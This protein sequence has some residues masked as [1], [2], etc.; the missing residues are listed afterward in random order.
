[1]SWRTA[2]L[3]EFTPRVSRL[4]LV[5]DPDDLLAEEGVLTGIRER[6]FELIEFEDAVSFR[7]A[8]ESRFRS[9]WDDGEDTD[10][11]VVLRAQSEDLSSLPY[12]LLQAG[13]QLSFSLGDLFPSLGYRVVASLDRSYLD[14]L[15]EAQAAHRPARLGDNATKGFVLRHVFDI[16]PE[17][18]KAPSDLLRVLLRRHYAG[19]IVPSLLDERFVEHLRRQESFAGWPLE[20]IVPERD[21]FFS[22]LQERWG[23]FVDLSAAIPADGVGEA[24]AA[25][26]MRFPGPLDLPFEHQ[27]VRIYLDNLFLEG[28][29]RPVRRPDG[30]RLATSWIRVG[31]Q[32]DP[33]ADGLARLQGLLESLQEG[34]PTEESTHRDW[35][36]FAR[37][38]AELTA[39]AIS[40]SEGMPASLAESVGGLLDETDSSFLAWCEAKY[41]TLHNLPPIPPA[42]VHH[43]PRWLSREVMQNGR[44]KAA[45]V[46]VDGL[47]LDQW[48]VARD[49]LSALP[50]ALSFRESAVFAWVPTITSVSRQAAVSG[51]APMFFPASILSTDKEAEH[52]QQFWVDRGLGQDESAFARCSSDE[53][54]AT[55]RA[56]LGQEKVR[57][58]AVVTDTVDKMMHGMVLGLAGMHSQVAQWVS[59]GFPSSLLG[60]L[61]ERGFKVFLTA[62]HGNVEATGCGRPSEGGL[63]DLKGRRARVYPTELLRE[64]VS[65][66]F[67]GAVDWPPIGLPQRFFPLLAPPRR[68]FTSGNERIVTHGGVSL[69]EVVVPLV[70]VRR[71]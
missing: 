5:A 58:L 60:M 67:P 8:Y 22:F 64:Q 35:L 27:D 34:L 33:E 23:R 10:L 13:R 65:R 7:Y 52:W 12:D 62:D 14:A 55:L 68:A 59:T 25:Y 45:L 24:H 32:T 26:D 16:A 61:L 69:A 50:D 39:L 15:W 47:A 42:M 29:L 28:L 31:I 38:R 43:V 6:G 56:L 1:M 51:R 63:A 18:V 40:C 44:A 54:L 48:V 53:D 20:S 17:L 37:R 49:A 30:D 57:T 71:N 19:Q 36:G 2:I 70:E 9:R 3:E 4:T 21:E 41:A 66:D 11:V 46:V